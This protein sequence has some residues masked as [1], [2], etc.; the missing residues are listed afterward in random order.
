M[1]NEQLVTMIKAGDD[2]AGNM[3]KLWEQNRPFIAMTARKF[4][5]YEEAEDLQQQGYI[6]LCDAVDGYRAEEGVPFINYAALWIRRGMAR[7]VEECGRLIRLPSDRS[8]A[9][10]QYKKLCRMYEASLGRGP[11]EWEVSRSLEISRE[12]ARSLERDGN[13]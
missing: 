5:G 11:T 10:R 1:T 2:V 9:V 4:R 13:L 3:L 6:A 8:A 7:Y 12:Q